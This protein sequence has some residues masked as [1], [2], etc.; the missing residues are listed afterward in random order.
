MYLLIIT[1][2]MVTLSV[3][4]QLG[5][6]ILSGSCDHHHHDYITEESITFKVHKMI[7]D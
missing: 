2:A 7:S 3:G 1:I 4:G 6:V 5:T